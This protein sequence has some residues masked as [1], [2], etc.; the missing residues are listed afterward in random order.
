MR[1]PALVLALTAAVAGPAALPAG[2]K[3]FDIVVY[4]GTSGGIAAAI[5]AAR[6]GKSVVLIEPSEH[7]G[8]LTSG[9][10]GVTDSGGKA[11]VGG[12]APRVFQP[13]E[14]QQHGPAGRE[15]RQAGEKKNYPPPP[16]A[17]VV[18]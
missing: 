5:Q 13:G 16:D 8:G 10:L 3:S 14:K 15:E 1:L 7:I 9:G 4:G 18:V 2:E 6:M 11:A 12:G 17:P